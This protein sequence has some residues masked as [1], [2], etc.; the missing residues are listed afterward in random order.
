MLI[1]DITVI[2]SSELSGDYRDLLETK[3]VDRFGKSQINY[4]VDGN[5]I[6]GLKIIVGDQEYRYDL[7]S[8]LSFILN[9]ITL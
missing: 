8:E 5:I 9:S 1:N 6:L 7:G 4:E 2:S 3:L